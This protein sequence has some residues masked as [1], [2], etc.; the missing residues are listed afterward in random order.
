MTSL[1]LALIMLYGCTS[2]PCSNYSLLVFVIPSRVTDNST[3][4][5]HRS[6]CMVQH[7]HCCNSSSCQQYHDRLMWK[8]S[9]FGNRFRHDIWRLIPK[10]SHGYLI[11]LARLLFINLSMHYSTVVLVHIIYI[12]NESMISIPVTCRGSGMIHTMDMHQ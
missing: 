12:E 2:T 8:L 4:L 11:P 9:C 10:A 3:Y 1:Q 6:L 5:M 7:K